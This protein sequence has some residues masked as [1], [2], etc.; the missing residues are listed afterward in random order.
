MKKIKDKLF[1][2]L[3]SVMPP[4]DV[5][6]RQLSDSCENRLK[7]IDNIKLNIHLKTC[8]WCTNYGHQIRF[9][10]EVMKKRSQKIREDLRLSEASKNKLKLL[11][12]SNL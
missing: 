10:S 4:C 6:V 1:Y 11:I 2:W 5:I 12:K 9:I 8:P 7:V 3:V